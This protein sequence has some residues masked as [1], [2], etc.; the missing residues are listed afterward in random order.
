[1]SV[2]SKKCPDCAEE[3][4]AEANVCKHCGSRFNGQAPASQTEGQLAAVG[5]AA[6]QAGG[7]QVVYVER[8][9]NGFAVASLAA[10]IVGL[11]FGLGPAIAYVM[12]LALGAL[13]VVFG[14]IG[15]KKAK[16]DPAIGRKTMATWGVVLGIIAFG[17]GIAGAV[18]VEEAVQDVER[19]LKQLEQ[20]P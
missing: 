15:H 2:T 14:L 18:T 20:G 4:L 6:S 3:V 5:A 7:G 16:R 1:M 17:L 8:R 12:A 11:L 10:G 13:A 19:D 9:S